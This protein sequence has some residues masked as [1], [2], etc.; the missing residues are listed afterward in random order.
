MRKVYTEADVIFQPLSTSPRF[1]DL[2]G[3]AFSQL[4]VLGYAGKSRWWCKCD[5][6]VICIVPRGAFVT[7]RQVS[8]GCYRRSNTSQL[9]LKH[10]ATL[11]RTQSPEYRSYI[12]AKGRIQN[13]N[14][15]AYP[16]YGGRGLEFGF[17]SFEEFFTEV[18][19]KPSKLH[20]L[21][22]INNDLGYLP[23]NVTWSTKKEQARNR[24]SN[25]LLEW[26]GKT[27][28]VSAWAE[29]LGIH[30]SALHLRL[31][32]GW[33]IENAIKTSVRVSKRSGPRL[34]EHAGRSQSLAAWA[35]D[36]GILRETIAKRLSYGWSVG[37]ALSRPIRPPA[38]RG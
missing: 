34:L 28:S 11:G 13:R 33:L 14:H 5:C 31:S 15:P 12:G 10:G 1:Q 17:S 9:K 25:R 22:R 2:T 3:Q 37:E 38:R 6:G 35:R 36:L 19:A 7:A 8:C 27:Q 23:G 16:D 29:D 20:T 30:R 18:G 4:N 26:R 21:D 32:R 24:R